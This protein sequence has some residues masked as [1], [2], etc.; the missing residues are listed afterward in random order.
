[1][2]CVTGECSIARVLC[3]M[4]MHVM[5]KKEDART[6]VDRLLVHLVTKELLAGDAAAAGLKEVMAM[7]DDISMDVPKF[8]NYVGKTTGLM[9][10]AGGVAP[11]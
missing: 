2:H 5:E 8:G 7:V 6:K 3:S 11:S 4:I 1:M 9:A 10:A